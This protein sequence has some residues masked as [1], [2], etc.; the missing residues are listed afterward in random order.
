VLFWRN[1]G[2]SAKWHTKNFKGARRLTYPELV[3]LRK[4]RFSARV[5]EPDQPT[6]REGR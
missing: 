6:T 2:I 5:E 4:R 1:W 3:V